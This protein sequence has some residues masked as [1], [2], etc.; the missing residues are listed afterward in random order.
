MSYVTNFCKIQFKN[1]CT[2]SFMLL[3]E[4]LMLRKNLVSFDQSFVS[5]SVEEM[6]DI[7][8]SICTQWAS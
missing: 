1:V 4:T 3:V 6:D 7:I 2:P 8:V 5:L